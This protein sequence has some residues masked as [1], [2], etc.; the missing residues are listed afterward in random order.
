MKMDEVPLDVVVLLCS[1]FWDSHIAVRLLKAM[2]YG[3]F[4]ASEFD[5]H[6]SDLH[7]RGIDLSRLG[8]ILRAKLARKALRAE[9]REMAAQVRQ[10]RLMLASLDMRN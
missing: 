7:A 10:Q 4:S 6:K 3:P 1:H 8:R 2:G 5:Q 9:L